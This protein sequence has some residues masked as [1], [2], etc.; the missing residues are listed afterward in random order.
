MYGTSCPRVC[1]CGVCLVC[2][3]AGVH[4]LSTFCRFARAI[5]WFSPLRVGVCVSVR[6]WVH[7]AGVSTHPPTPF[8]QLVWW[9]YLRGSA[10]GPAGA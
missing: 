9:W 7:V 3:G 5:G 2:V 10:H 1:I 6:V 4:G 8:S